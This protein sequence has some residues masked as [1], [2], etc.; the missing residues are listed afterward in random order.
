MAAKHGKAADEEIK[1]L[2]KTNWS[3]ELREEYSNLTVSDYLD[4]EDFLGPLLWKR[5]QPGDEVSPH[6]LYK[7][8]KKG[9]LYKHTLYPCHRKDIEI[10]WEL[11]K[12]H[13]VDTVVDIEAIGAGKSLKAATIGNICLHEIYT[14]P[15]FHEKFNMNFGDEVSIIIMGRSA[16]Q[17]SLVTYK[18][19]IPMLNTKFLSK[20]FPPPIDFAE[21]EMRE[22]LPS[23]VKMPFGPMI[24]PGTGNADSALGFSP[25]VAI[26]DEA[27]HLVLTPESKRAA[28]I[29]YGGRYDAAEQMYSAIGGRIESRFMIGGKNYGLIIMMSDPKYMG[30]FLERKYLEARR[31]PDFMRIDRWRFY[32]ARMF[33]IR[34]PLWVAKPWAFSG[35]MLKFDTESL[36]IV[37]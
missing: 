10:L 31:A 19:M 16:V 9:D 13:D 34:R 5:V 22:R 4:G 28:G 18:K 3:K 17:S 32:G 7:K 27:N 1:A 29:A 6:R 30:D 15:G 23:V 12:T 35:K 24:F 21:V 20:Y 33:C 14:T 26:I 2:S 8:D 37:G 25:Y 36:S 11:R